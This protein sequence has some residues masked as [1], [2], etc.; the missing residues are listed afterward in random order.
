MWVVKLGGSLAA[1]NLLEDWLDLLRRHGAGRVVI[2]PGGGPFA[3]QVRSAQDHWRFDD[4]VA[5]HMA[6]LA[7]EQF[8]LMLTGLR[9]DLVPVRSARAIQVALRGAGIPVWLPAAMLEHHPDVA[10]SW[11]V[12]SDSLAAWLAAQMGAQRLILVKS[13]ARPMLEASVNELSRQ[14]ILDAAFPAFNARGRH[15]LC[16]LDKH[17]LLPMRDMLLDADPRGM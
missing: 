16:L 11:D 6:L 1:A 5:H 13:C 10:Q 2:V 14:G 4:P 17:D 15:R 8:A 12:T 9:P 3:D 7:M